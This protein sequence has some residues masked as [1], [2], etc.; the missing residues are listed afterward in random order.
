[1]PRQ[2]QPQPK[3]RRRVPVP[4]ELREQLAELHELIEQAKY[5][6]DV[7]LGYDDAVQL[8][9]LAGGMFG[10]KHRPFVLTFFPEPGVRVTWLLTLHPTE[11]EDIGDGRQTELLLDCCTSPDCRNKFREADARCI[12]CDYVGE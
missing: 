10:K 4:A 7:E 11:I 9:R 12:R 8:P 1:M 6:P 3:D 5:D 2:L